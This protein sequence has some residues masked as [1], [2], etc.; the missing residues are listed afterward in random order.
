MEYKDI[1]DLSKTELDKKFKSSKAELF[2]LK[3][4][5][6]LGQLANPI[7]IRGARRDL[8]RIQTAMTLKSIAPKGGKKK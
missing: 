5:N 4:K 8:A 6:S 7:E 3:M 2:S 1:K